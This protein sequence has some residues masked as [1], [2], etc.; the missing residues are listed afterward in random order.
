[1][2]LDE[3]RNR[4]PDRYIFLDGPAIEGSPD[5]RIL[6]DLA[7]FV[8]L[9]VGYGMDSPETITKTALLFDPAKFVGV[10][11]NERP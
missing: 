2:A 10:V 9:V 1:M 6:S 4:Y 11:F 5:A 8:I 3:L 7:D